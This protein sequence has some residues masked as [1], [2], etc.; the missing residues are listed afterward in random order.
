MSFVG[1]RCCVSELNLPGYDIMTKYVIISAVAIAIGMLALPYFVSRPSPSVATSIVG[2]EDRK[3]VLGG[4]L[5]ERFFFSDPI[6]VKYVPLSG[7][8]RQE[9]NQ[10]LLENDIVQLKESPIDSLPEM[11]PE[12][13]DPEPISPAVS[14]A[15]VIYRRI[16]L[17]Q[18]ES[19]GRSWIVFHANGFS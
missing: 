17:I 4:I 9:L 13:A 14:L 11:A 12:S 10:W 6:Q 1:P 2:L 16:A 15:S 7:H 19:D 3:P 5:H 18:R 8:E